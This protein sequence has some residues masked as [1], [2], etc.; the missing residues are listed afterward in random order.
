MGRSSFFGRRPPGWPERLPKGPQ[1]CP[2]IA[3]RSPK[4]TLREPLWLPNAPGGLRKTFKGC[5]M[6][7]SPG[8]FELILSFDLTGAPRFPSPM[9]LRVPSH[10]QTRR[11]IVPGRTGGNARGTNAIAARTTPI[12]ATGTAEA[13]AT[14]ATPTDAARGN[15]TDTV[16]TTIPT[17]TPNTTT[18]LFSS[19]DYYY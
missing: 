8:L 6:C 4:R 18:T 19:L 14:H 5:Q 13:I 16:T 17:T 15:A 10:G 3:P 2:K 7:R 12:T 1:E 11:C 9:L